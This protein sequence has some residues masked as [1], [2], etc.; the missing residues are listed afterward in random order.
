[1]KKILLLMIVILFSGCGYKI[2]K[3]S[4][5]QFNNDLNY[6]SGYRKGF[7][8][9]IKIQEP[10]KIPECQN[11]WCFDKLMECR[12]DNEFEVMAKKSACETD[13][14]MAYDM[15]LSPYIRQVL[16]KSIKENCKHHVMP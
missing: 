12:K 10:C 6:H 4:T 13:I 5:I 7:D 16:R 2:I 14:K 11:G 1:M 15:S 9:G 8:K 3:K